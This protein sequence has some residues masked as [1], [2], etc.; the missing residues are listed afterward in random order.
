[1]V[2]EHTPFDGLCFFLWAVSIWSRYLSTPLT[3]RWRVYSVLLGGHTALVWLLNARLRRASWVNSFDV[4]RSTPLPCLLR[5]LFSLLEHSLA[6]WCPLK[7]CPFLMRPLSGAVI[8]AKPSVLAQ[9]LC[10]WDWS[11]H[12]AC[13]AATLLGSSWIPSAE[14]TFLKNVAKH[15]LNGLFF[16]FRV[17]LWLC[18]SC[19]ILILP[20]WHQISRR[21]H[22]YWWH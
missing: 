12:A 6:L 19:R 4:D 8:C 14:N 11:G 5:A 9:A 7:L 16:M 1:M 21:H 13:N 22:R 2:C 15:R 17:S 10:V 18:H 3:N 20:E